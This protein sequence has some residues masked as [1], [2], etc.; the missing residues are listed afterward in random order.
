MFL[1][2]V[3]KVGGYWHL[4]EARTARKRPGTANG[5][6]DKPP[7]RRIIWPQMSVML[8]L[9]NLDRQK[10]LMAG[11]LGVAFDNCPVSGTTLSLIF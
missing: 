4:I 3:T 7:Q 11:P 5:A 9:R 2:V 8:S 1:V 10:K 6:Q